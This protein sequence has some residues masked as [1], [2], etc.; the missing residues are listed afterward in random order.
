MVLIQSG[1]ENMSPCGVP[2][3]TLFLVLMSLTLQLVKLF[4]SLEDPYQ[5]QIGL[6]IESVLIEA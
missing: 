3:H 1:G 5:H 6:E 4:P 2:L